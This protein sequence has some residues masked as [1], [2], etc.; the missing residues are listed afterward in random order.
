MKPRCP[1]HPRFA[2]DDCP[3]CEALIA[4]AEWDHDVPADERAAERRYERWLGGIG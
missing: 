2:V 3:A 4:R 1:T